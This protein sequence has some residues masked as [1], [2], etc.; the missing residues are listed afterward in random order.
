MGVCILDVVKSLNFQSCYGIG[1]GTWGIDQ[2]G[3]NHAS[4]YSWSHHDTNFN[5]APKVV[6][7]SV[8]RV[9]NFGQE[10]LFKL[11]LILRKV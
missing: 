9:G 6:N 3:E 4:A 5:S 2:V 10:I 7:M 8:F 11:L 1:K